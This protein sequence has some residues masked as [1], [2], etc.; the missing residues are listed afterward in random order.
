MGRFVVAAFKPRPGMQDRLLSVVARHWGV[1]RAQGLV[2]DKPSHVMRATDG[3]LVEV[4]EWTS[5]EAI[6]RAHGNAA[7]QALWEE[8]AAVCDYVPVGSLAESQHVF[9]EF[10]AV[11]F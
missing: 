2:T 5:A 4:F 8:F 11:E 10:D 3:T 9:S 1:L 7:V 6:D